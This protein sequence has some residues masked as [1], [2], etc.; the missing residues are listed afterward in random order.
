MTISPF[1]ASTPP[2]LVRSTIHELAH[3]PLFAVKN[4]A[5]SWRDALS[6]DIYETYGE[7]W[8]NAVE[9]H[10]G[11]LEVVYIIIVMVELGMGME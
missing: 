1:L 2:I 10:V 9:G 4:L 8:H 5:S 3:I 7:Q 6:E 11:Y